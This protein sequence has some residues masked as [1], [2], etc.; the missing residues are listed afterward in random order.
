MKKRIVSLLI[1]AAMLIELIPASVLGA[2]A[3]DGETAT[4][5]ERPVEIT[6]VEETEDE[7]EVPPEA[8]IEEE[9][10][11]TV[12]EA[13]A[14]DPDAETEEEADTLPEADA[15]EEP[16]AI[17]EGPAEE[18]LEGPAEGEAEPAEPEETELQEA[19][20]EEPAEEPTDLDEPLEEEPADL[21]E[22]VEAPNMPS[23]H[24]EG[25]ANTIF[26][27][28]D[29]PE[30]AFPEGTK[31][32]VKPV[33][34]S[35]VLDSVADA[36]GAERKNVIAVDISFWYE[37]EEIEP[38]APINVVLTS[39][40]IEKVEEAQVVHVDDSGEAKV[41]EEADISGKTAEF[42]SD[43]FSVY[44]IATTPRLN[45]IIKSGTTELEN[46]YLKSG[47]DASE[48]VYDPGAGE[49]GDKVF[50]GWTTKENYT[51][52]DA[53][54]AMTF[55]QVQSDASSKASS[56][57]ADGSVTYY[58]MLYDTYTVTYIDLPTGVEGEPTVVLKTD[59]LLVKESDTVAY[60]VSQ[61]YSPENP[62]TQAFLGWIPDETANVSATGIAAEGP[63][64]NET[65][66][67]V[68]GNVTFMPSVPYGNWLIF[69]EMGGTYTMPQFVKN[70]EK[71]TEP[72]APTKKGYTFSKWTTDEAGENEF[73]F[74]SELSGKTVVYAQYTPA[75]TAE[76]TILIWKQNVEGTG[77]DFGD[78]IHGTGNVD[79]S[80]NDLVTVSDTS[81]SV[82]GTSY[83]Y[84][85][86]TPN[87]LGDTVKIVPEGTATLNVFFDR[88]TVTLNFYI[89]QT[90]GQ[91]GYVYTPV[92]P[93]SGASGRYYTSNTA[94]N[95]TQVYY[96]AAD[97]KWYTNRQ[98]S[99][100]IYDYTYSG[101]SYS[102]VYT[103]EYN[104]G[105]DW[106][107]FKQL[108]G[109]YG[110]KIGSNWPEDYDWYANGG[111]NG[112]TSGT[113]TTFMD[114]FLP[115]SGYTE[116][117]YGSEHSGSR[118]IYFQQ[119]SASDP[120]SYST[121]NTVTAARDSS[122][123]ISDKYNG[124]TAYQ[125][126]T[127]G[128]SW[129]SVGTKGSNG[130]YNSGRRV[131]YDRQLYIR[132]NRDR[133]D[134]NFMDG[135]YVNPKADMRTVYDNTNYQLSDAKNIVYGASLSDYAPGGSAEI[136]P[137]AQYSG[138]LFDGWY[139][140]KA[141]QNP[142]DFSKLNMPEGGLT[143]YAR[144]IMKQYRVILHADLPDD[145]IQATDDDGNA[146]DYF[147][148]ESWSFRANEGE[149]ISVSDGIA[150]NYEFDGWYR[151][152]DGKN[153][154][155]TD[156][157]PATSAI[158]SEYDKNSEYSEWTIDGP[159]TS[160]GN[161]DLTGYNGGERFWVT[162]KIDLY[163]KWR[164]ITV[165][166]DGIG[167]V[168]EANGIDEKTGDTVS[169]STSSTDDKLYK[170]KAAAF[171]AP[172]SSP[173]DDTKQFL[174]WQIQKWDGSKFVDSGKKVFPGA[175]FDV[176]VNNAKIVDEGGNV[177][178]LSAVEEGKT[179]TY[180]VQLMAV[181]GDLGE[182]LM[183]KVKFDPNG[184]NLSDT[185]LAEKEYEVNTEITV[186][187][188]T[189]AGYTFLGWGV[190]ATAT[191]PLI[192]AD[193]DQA[194]AADKIN[195]NAWDTDKD[196][197][198]LYALWDESEV[199]IKYAV[200]DDSTGYEGVSVSPTSEKVMADT[201]EAKGST[202]ASTTSKYVIDYWTKDE[203][204]DK[205]GTNAKFVP[206]KG[207]E[208][209]YEAR[210]YYAHFKL[211]EVDVTVHHYL[212]GTTTK[213][214]EDVTETATIGDSYTAE[215]ATAFIAPYTDLA[216]SNEAIKAITVSENAED[217]VVN[218]YYTIAITVKAD[219]KS[220][221]FGQDDPELT[222]TV[223]GLPEGES[224]TGYEL[225]REA[226]EA[227]GTY[228]ITPA[229]DATSGYYTIEYQT[230]TLTITAADELVITVKGEKAEYTYDGSAKTAEGYTA[231][232][233]NSLYD[234]TKL[235]FTGTDS[236]TETDAGTYPMG[237]KV[238]DFSYED[239][240]NFSKVTINVED[241]QLIINPIKDKVTVTITENSD[242]VTYD[243]SEHT[244]T[245]YET[246]ESDNTLYVVADSVE[247]T[248]TDAW[249]VTETD[250]GT[251]DMGIVAGDFKNTNKNFTNVVFEI[252]D[253]QLV[254][255][256]IKD[257]VT[258][259]ITENSDE[260]DYD[261]NEHTITGYK[262]IKS[263]NEKYDVTKSVE[264]TETDAWTVTKTDAGTYDM[265]IV[266]GDFKNINKNFSNVVFEVTDGQLVINP[267]E[268]TIKVN[269]ASKYYGEEDPEFE[270]TVTGLVKDGDLGEI[271]YERTNTAEDV[272]EYTEVL[273]A[274][275]TENANYSVTVEKGD[276]EIKKA[277]ITDE[278]RFEISDPED[279][280]YNGT[281]QKQPVTVKD[282]LTGKTLTEDTDYTLTYD[283]DTTNVGTVKVTVEG[284]G[285]YEGKVD[286]D[287]DITKV[288]VTIKIKDVTKVYDGTVLDASLE[289]Y[290]EYGTVEGL[291]NGEVANVILNGKITHV[292]ETT[293]FVAYTDTAGEDDV[294]YKIEWA[295]AVSPKAAT[296]PTA[297]ALESNYELDL[298]NSEIGKMEITPAELTIKTGSKSKEYDGSA[299]KYDQVDVSGIV[300]A[301][302]DE[303]KVTV[304][305]SQ[306]AVGNSKNTYEITWGNA[307]EKD[308]TVKETLGTLTVTQK[309]DPPTPP[310]PPPP[311]PT[312]PPP[313]PPTPPE[314]PIEEPEIPEAEPEPEIIPEPDTPAAQP[315]WALI[316]LISTILAGGLSLGM[317][318]TYF[319]KKKEEEEDENG[320]K[321]KK[322]DD[323][324][325]D[326]V[327]KHGFTRL[328]SLVP[329]IGS[330]V[331]FLLTENMKNPMVL[332]DKWTL[333]MVVMALANVLLA[334]LSRKTKKDEEE[335]D[336]RKA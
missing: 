322:E 251:Y 71:P 70:G 248:K 264:E 76:Y 13:L 225:G 1:T 40:M 238:A 243:G 85:G 325:D 96:N 4:A 82:S 62:N 11:A 269:D 21:E 114:A 320:E 333:L 30:G 196:M 249:T 29:A 109:L 254:I 103:R 302:K 227:V 148:T 309:S 192:A 312:P 84:Q 110:S 273:D 147:G 132:F 98:W 233:T 24:F 66:V 221:T 81:I 8:D 48:I 72:T 95:A 25:S 138:Y 180:T 99:W 56:L 291:V 213:V 276:F 45:V 87:E 153:V 44:A 252:V 314:E 149:R 277:N 222:A 128:T 275:Y 168:Y 55:A 88:V 190:S 169:G 107:I 271:T 283:G 15:D 2:F 92:T 137:T 39:R 286:K 218:V 181:Y 80:I 14:D 156:A 154:F 140:D 50:R 108:S 202:A 89:W 256:P 278:T 111:N 208:G 329:G 130:Y 226:G 145:I 34:D 74:N 336:K 91:A 298:E 35:D 324:D 100:A 300:D 78:V 86:F 246:I 210:T 175:T 245:G 189:R 292:E 335:E 321:V 272:G 129:T 209:I 155:D 143:V 191:D 188:A 141:C 126:S 257:K 293:D 37:E 97:G 60:T 51:V 9:P 185:A 75:Q 308:Y 270:G 170:D 205:V 101:N 212:K 200:A 104:D 311:P 194:W 31:M 228:T 197:N 118:T 267:A 239:A 152:E 297:T 232:S 274:K 16:E 135:L 3:D 7:T 102:T 317:L 38:M 22:P 160:R 79:A 121:I 164:A 289:D 241:G 261:G 187:G 305:G 73:D 133:Y 116:N 294:W 186:P 281:E 163:A 301:D 59:T 284:K 230:G 279:T 6:Y 120:S 242:K 112:T 17:E 259:T 117:F 124:F 19:V 198:I 146:I 319:T 215:A 211:N 244:I 158:A 57:S 285:N 315:V 93:T 18:P 203:G 216:L 307:K 304:T 151:D 263:D 214:A 306:T 144:W 295:K 123:Y 10:E 42:S 115:P 296:R 253:G 204:T 119:Q 231:E 316:N 63:Y 27:T 12:A 217:N 318:G 258:V 182:P 237:L 33:F 159:D 162:Q 262:E 161:K 229:G 58:A 165:G 236:V 65:A 106:V 53:D 303:I 290:Y 183:V 247:E 206:E 166:A 139:L 195:R 36:A 150:K 125:Y 220:K 49:L 266:A 131:E 26:V 323:E 23:R 207:T 177:V 193:D 299:L 77:Y 142:V 330:I 68:K 64:P 171:A 223:D 240:A 134:I 201:G 172:A 46:V 280:P 94:N 287:Y 32:V 199:E 157:H 235:K 167:V 260:V 179:Y 127:N 176:L 310:P 28:V 250:A 255:D 326:N 234:S 328:L 327:K 136:T 69:K 83:S 332:T 54:S 67:T 61:A 282:L 105:R 184:G 224:F 43:M 313:E 113:R 47:D 288:K 90:D 265:G 268:V 122:F 334:F 5:T 20:E 178:A 331:T 52:A 174:Y 41:I 173:S 219:D